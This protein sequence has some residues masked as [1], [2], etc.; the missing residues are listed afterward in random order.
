MSAE[1]EQGSTPE[2]TVNTTDET[3]PIELAGADEL[4]DDQLA[5]IH[6]GMTASPAPAPV[7]GEK[8]TLGDG[9]TA[10]F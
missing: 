1:T 5:S 3:S 7:F 10:S 8:E 9:E 2:E 4:S 6:G